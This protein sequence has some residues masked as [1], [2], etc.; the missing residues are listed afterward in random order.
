MTTTFERLGAILTR[1]YQVTPESLTL[2][3]PLDGLGIDSLG[4]VELLWSVE[5]EFGIKF[6]EEP[7]MLALATVGDVV[8]SIDALLRSP[9]VRPTVSATP[10]SVPGADPAITQPS[11]R[12]S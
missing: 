12:A 4:T 6:T 2:S 10:N 7:A 3:A 1:D 5:D 9:G 11:E 8:D